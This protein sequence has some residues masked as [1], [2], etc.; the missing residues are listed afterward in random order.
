[1]VSAPSTEETILYSLSILHVFMTDEL[2]TQ[3]LVHA[4]ALPSV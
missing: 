4:Q 1:M 2:T 3:M